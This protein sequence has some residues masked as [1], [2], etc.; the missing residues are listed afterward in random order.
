MARWYASWQRRSGK[1]RSIVD[2][3]HFMRVLLIFGP[4][5]WFWDP[6]SSK[7]PGTM[8]RIPPFLVAFALL[9]TGALTTLFL[10][11]TGTMF[12]IT[13][14]LFIALAI[15]GILVLMALFVDKAIERKYPNE[16][17]SQVIL[18]VLVAVGYAFAR[19]CV[20]ATIWLWWPLWKLIL[21]IGW[22]LD[23]YVIDFLN[24]VFARPLFYVSIRDQLI[25][26]WIYPILAIMLYI[27]LL[28]VSMKWTLIVTIAILTVIVVSVATVAGVYALQQW[29]KNR[30]RR[31]RRP[32][33]T[34]HFTIKELEEI[35]RRKEAK[36]RKKER[37]W[38][39]VKL[40]W[41]FLVAKKH[42][43]CPLIDMTSTDP[44]FEPPKTP[45]H[46]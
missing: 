33:A 4:W 8:P 2:L 26:I 18:D 45:A 32:T 21:G 13:K 43:I 40:F 39:G 1:N 31:S 25:G 44:D 23:N 28:L 3:C 27:G 5:R 38:R 17:V 30:P 34:R 9:I 10:L 12:F 29:V 19:V 14:W 37:R 16:Q 42:R 22:L 36:R 15:A 7:D 11:F 6:F 24:R 20:Y 41:Q 35:D 46:F